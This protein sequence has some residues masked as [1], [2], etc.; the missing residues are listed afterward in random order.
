VR[1]RWTLRARNCD[2]LVGL[3]DA[4]GDVTAARAAAISMA[5]TTSR[6]FIR[7]SIDHPTIRLLKQSLIAHR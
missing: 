1:A 3:N 6:A 7:E 5:A 4:V 2:P